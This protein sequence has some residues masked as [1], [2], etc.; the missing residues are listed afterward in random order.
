MNNTLEVI[1]QVRMPL[2]GFEPESQAREACILPKTFFLAGLD[3][4]GTS[5]NMVLMAE[6][7]KLWI[8]SIKIHT[9]TI[10][11]PPHRFREVIPLIL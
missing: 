5:L 10:L 4:M 3:Y 7:L 2:S 8:V 9:A 11:T 6:F 1:T